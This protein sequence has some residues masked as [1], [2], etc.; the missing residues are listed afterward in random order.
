M[1]LGIGLA[2]AGVVL[3]RL[4][5][6]RHQWRVTEHGVLRAVLGAVVVGY[7]VALVVVPK[8]APSTAVGLG[9]AA[10]MLVVGLAA[11][12]RRPTDRAATG[13]DD[14]STDK[15]AKRPERWWLYGGAV[16]LVAGIA[17]STVAARHEWRP[18]DQLTLQR[19]STGQTTAAVQLATAVPG[20]HLEVFDAG[21]AVMAEVLSATT[22]TQTLAIPPT[23]VNGSLQVVLVVPGS[24]LS[25]SG[26]NGAR[27]SPNSR[28]PA[29]PAR[30]APRRA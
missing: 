25:V 17:L 2:V 27:W 1:V 22:T 30:R 29:T 18:P 16:L 13:N 12:W 21:H 4:R 5:R 10:V 19:S 6:R 28:S 20:T 15:G 3:V 7:V 9:A 11:T 26:S 8:H 23:A 24:S 14:G